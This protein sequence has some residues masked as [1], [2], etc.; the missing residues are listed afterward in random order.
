[1]GEPFK[2]YEMKEWPTEV[3]PDLKF[4]IMR[5]EDVLKVKPH[6]LKT[7]YSLDLDDNLYDLPGIDDWASYAADEIQKE[8]NKEFVREMKAWLRRHKADRVMKRAVR[9][10]TWRRIKGWFVDRRIRDWFVWP[11]YPA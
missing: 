2:S 5:D 1:M 6:V 4:T 11:D 10:N 9:R 7:Q 3:A 8:I